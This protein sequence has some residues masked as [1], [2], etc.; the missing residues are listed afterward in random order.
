LIYRP[1]H[2]AIANVEK[3]QSVA[4]PTTRKKHLSVEP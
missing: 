4:E 3:G 1:D 2:Y